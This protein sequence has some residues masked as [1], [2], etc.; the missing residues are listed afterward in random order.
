MLTMPEMSVQLIK[1][2]NTTKEQ[3]MEK[4]KPSDYPQ[5]GTRLSPEMIERLNNE[6]KRQERS[7]SQIVRFALTEYLDKAEQQK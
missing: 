3:K 6:A 1:S 5:V 7:A 4:K 2:S